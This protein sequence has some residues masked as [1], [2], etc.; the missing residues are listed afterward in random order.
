M[1]IPSTHQSVMPYLILNNAS[2]FY[3]FAQMVFDAETLHLEKQE[4]NETIRHG[5]IKIGDST[6][7]FS[8][9]R[10]EWSAQTANLFI[11]V[12]D[13]D[14]TYQKA[15]DHSAISVMELSDAEYG[16]TCGVKDPT[17]NIWWIT[18]VK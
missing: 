6:I 1:T 10:P 18:S 13:A 3:D 14:D 9:S 8:N 12:E 17:G 7:M 2:K 11:Y 5:E 16:R 4:D 15:L